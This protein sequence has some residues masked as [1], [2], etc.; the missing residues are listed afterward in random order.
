MNGAELQLW[1]NAALV[2]NSVHGLEATILLRDDTKVTGVNLEDITKVSTGD[3]VEE[4]V[5][6]FG[7]VST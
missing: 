5:V 3:V 7:L 2:A 1:L 6:A 4:V